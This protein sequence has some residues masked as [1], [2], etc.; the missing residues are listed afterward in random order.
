[1][2]A[3]TS[4]PATDASAPLPP[5]IRGYPVIGAAPGLLADPFRFSLEAVERSSGAARVN[6]GLAELF[7]FGR[8]DHA[9]QILRTRAE[10]FVKAGGM[11]DAAQ[12]I[13]GPVLPTTEGEVWRR[14]RRLMQPQFLRQRL[15]GM[16]RLMTTAVEEELARWRERAGPGRPVELQR[17]MMRITMRIFIRTMYSTGIADSD[18][19][20]MSQASDITLHQLNLRMWTSFL[21]PWLPFPGDRKF[22]RARAFIDQTIYRIIEQRRQSGAQGDDLLGLLLRAQDD[23]TGT[24]MDARQIRDEAIS[25]LIAGY[26]TT[27]TALTWALFLLAQ[28]PEEEARLRDEVG[29][30][31]QGRAPT[32]EDLAQLSHTR[33]VF[34]EALRMYPPVWM[35]TRTALAADQVGGYRIPAGATVLILPYAIQHDA[36]LWEAPDS[37]RPERFAPSKAE[38]PGCA[39]MPFGAGSHQC[40]GNHLALMEGPLVLA[41]LAQRYRL[42]LVPDQKVVPKG[43][44]TLRPRDGIKVLVEP[45]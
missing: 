35:M 21:P 39:Y 19:E 41:M 43:S 18:V 4:A 8:A 29:R 45:A 32:F 23:E 30:V 2:Y 11:W 1:M 6:L 17:E 9:Q 40:I 16:T 13:L 25:L 3:Q 27:S 5:E 44:L 14:Q 15:A 33:M 10:N 22:R 37:F 20:A 7:L 12:R 34:Q 38:R 42:K 28:H 36:A 24:G 26:E 31:L